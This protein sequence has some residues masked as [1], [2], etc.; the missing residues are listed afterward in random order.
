LKEVER[1]KE[2]MGHKRAVM[3]N[4]NK[5]KGKKQNHVKRADVNEKE[6]T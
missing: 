3:M 1:S 6:E 2:L 5:E 4:E